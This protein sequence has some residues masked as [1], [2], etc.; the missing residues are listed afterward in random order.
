MGVCF[1]FLGSSLCFTS[2]PDLEEEW[3]MTHGVM[4]LFLQCE[5]SFWFS[6]PAYACVSLNTEQMESAKT[7]TPPSRP[8][9]RLQQTGLY[10]CALSLWVKL[11]APWGKSWVLCY[12]KV[13]VL[14]HSDIKTVCVC[15]WVVL[16]N[17]LQ[18]YVQY[19][20]TGHNPAFKVM[21][22]VQYRLSSIDNIYG[23]MSITTGNVFF[24]L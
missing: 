17:D 7:D 23:I 20:L 4:K 14:L 6:L 16:S 18:L 8:T 11:S 10:T 13:R 15:V 1:F 24:F 21:F 2:I 3:L 12:R 5:V 9:T 19:Q 22:Q